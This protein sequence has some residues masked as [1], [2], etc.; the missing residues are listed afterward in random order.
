M[1][2][3]TSLVKK[4]KDKK[5]VDTNLANDAFR[6]HVRTFFL[7]GKH[8]KEGVICHAEPCKV[9]EGKN[10]DQSVNVFEQLKVQT[11]EPMCFCYTCDR[12]F[13]VKCLKLDLE[14]FKTEKGPFLCSEC[15]SDSLNAAAVQY[16]TSGDWGKGVDARRTSFFKPESIKSVASLS[17][18]QMTDDEFDDDDVSS[19][20]PVQERVDEHFNTVSLEDH[21][22][23]MLRLGLIHKNHVDTSQS[24]ITKLKKQI[25]QLQE[26]LKQKNAMHPPPQNPNEESFHHPSGNSTTVPMQPNAYTAESIL[27][28]L[29]VSPRGVSGP[30]TSAPEQKGNDEARREKSF[31]DSL[32]ENVDESKLSWSDKI[33][34]SSTKTQM[35]VQQSVV[36]A[37]Q[38]DLRRKALPKITKFR[39]EAKSWITFKKE[40]TRYKETGCYDDEI[41]KMYILEALEGVALAR[42]EEMIDTSTLDE[43]MKVLEVSFGH[44]PSIIKAHEAEI[45]KVKIKGSLMRND[46]VHINSLIQ[47]YFTAC[48]YTKI[49]KL[50]SNMLAEHILNQL[51]GVH[52]VFFRQHFQK[53]RPRETTQVADLDI[54]YTFLEEIAQSLDV[55]V[56]EVSSDKKKPSQ[57]NVVSGG[58]SVSNEASAKENKISSRSTSVDKEAGYNMAQVESVPKKC[59]ACSKDGHFTVECEKYR[60]MTES[61]R[62]NFVTMRNL[63][64]N[65][66]LTSEHRAIMC[67]LRTECGYEVNGIKCVQKHHI[68][69]HGLLLRNTNFVNSSYQHI[70]YGRNGRGGRSGTNFNTRRGSELAR[71]SHSDENKGQNADQGQMSKPNETQSSTSASAPANV[72]SASQP[73]VVALSLTAPSTSSTPTVMSHQVY[74]RQCQHITLTSDRTVKLF[75]NFASGPN[76]E[77]EIYAIGDSA[78]EVTLIRDDL[79]EQLGIQGVRET[80]EL[81]LT[82]GRV[83]SIQAEKIN[84]ELRGQ[85]ATAESIMLKNVYAVSPLDVELPMRTLNVKQLKEKYQYL[86]NVPFES[87]EN[88]IPSLLLGSSHAFCFEAVEPVIE[89][90]EGRPVA[91]RSKLGWTIYGGEP[92]EIEIN[93]TNMPM[94]LNGSEEVQAKKFL[95]PPGRKSPPLET[96]RSN[97]SSEKRMKAKSFRTSKEQSGEI[98]ARNHVRR[99]Q[100]ITRSDN[101]PHTPAHMTKSMTRTHFKE[102]PP[103]ERDGK[104][105]GRSR[106]KLGW[107]SAHRRRRM[108]PPENVTIDLC[109]SE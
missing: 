68:T 107:M 76:G 100:R 28:E 104:S 18:E 26:S 94:H 73:K 62:V 83:R 106:W 96:L 47:T 109:H 42:V 25:E 53:E 17:E 29:F 50:N 77:A 49:A 91:V 78:S 12:S 32:L 71:S 40:V 74:R 5:F 97:F 44:S 65:C 38:L 70:G 20:V 105:R 60:A 58:S 84:V 95:S 31:I 9:Q 81:K 55:R 82:D 99:E 102:E 16:Y 86:N 54:L 80:L 64:R 79:R 33:L 56:D 98:F 37:K 36:K 27:R 3:K 41:I 11:F 14:Y 93:S 89:Q 103:S 88:A 75:K 8:V 90:G 7:A 59:Q 35:D 43:V 46:A 52:K 87:Y 34:L 45:L 19:F 22:R 13:H 6:T 85:H 51:D 48:R 30:Y 69:L 72:N 1:N 24:E 15:K 57:V 39:G 101:N 67:N 21:Q 92:E 63:C 2:D 108:G 61:Q 10:L 4:L 23:E 66:L